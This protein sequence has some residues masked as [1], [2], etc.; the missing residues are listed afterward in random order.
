MKYTRTYDVH[1]E[2]IQM[3]ENVKHT[4]L[5]RLSNVQMLPKHTKSK[6]AIYPPLNPANIQQGRVIE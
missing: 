5:H 3:L 1:L 6:G 4:W 2:L